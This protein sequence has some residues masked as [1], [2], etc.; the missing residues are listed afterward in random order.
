MLTQIISNK[1]GKFLMVYGIEIIKKSFPGCFNINGTGTTD[2]KSVA[3]GF[4]DFLKLILALDCPMVFLILMFR[5]I[6]FW[7]I[8]CLLKIHFSL[9]LRIMIR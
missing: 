3:D 2:F 6:I 8:F 9:I 5:Q 4:N 1:L 7:I